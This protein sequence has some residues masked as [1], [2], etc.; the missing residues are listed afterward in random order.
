[1]CILALLA[2]FTADPADRDGTAFSVGTA[3]SSFS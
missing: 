2:V 1:M 3:H